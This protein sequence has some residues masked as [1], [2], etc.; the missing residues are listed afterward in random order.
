MADSEKTPAMLLD[1]LACP[2]RR[3]G[4]RW[5]PQLC[6]VWPRSSPR[7]LTVGTRHTARTAG[8]HGSS[9]R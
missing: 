3:N 4:V 8:R 5:W 6:G 7:Y 1:E 9:L 2:D